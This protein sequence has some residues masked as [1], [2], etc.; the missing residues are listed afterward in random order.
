VCFVL[1]GFGIALDHLAADRLP[2]AP[3]ALTAGGM[4]LIIASSATM[5]GECRL[6][7]TQIRREI[8]L[9]SDRAFG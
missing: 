2:W 7:A 9:L 8:E 3:A 5:L 1:A 6:A 4:A